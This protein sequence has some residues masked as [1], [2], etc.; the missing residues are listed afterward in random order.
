MLLVIFI[1]IYS[2][3]RAVDYK[4]EKKSHQPHVLTV[5]VE[6]QITYTQNN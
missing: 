3:P 4:K 2:G 1:A 6:R 5:W